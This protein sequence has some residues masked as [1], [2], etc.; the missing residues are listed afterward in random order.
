MFLH[1]YFIL[2]KYFFNIFLDLA[3]PS[4]IIAWYKDAYQN[5]TDVVER[6][7]LCN[8][9]YFTIYLVWMNFIFKFVIPTTILVFCNVKILLRVIFYTFIVKKGTYSY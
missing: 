8:K 9:T 4:A 2:L 3:I 5:V 1:M 7:L 6:E